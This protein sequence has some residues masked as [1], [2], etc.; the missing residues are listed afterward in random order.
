MRHVAQCSEQLR[1]AAQNNE[2]LRKEWRLGPIRLVLPGAGDEPE[3]YQTLDANACT[4]ES[5]LDGL[6]GQYAL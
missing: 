5:Y 3:G 1:R 6:E 2:L 4:L